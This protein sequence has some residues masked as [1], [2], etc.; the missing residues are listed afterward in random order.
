M[1]HTCAWYSWR[2]GEGFGS[3]E[4]KKKKDVCETSCWCWKL[5]IG[6]VDGQPVLL[7]IE[8]SLQCATFDFTSSIPVF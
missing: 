7:N 1:D 5:N 4:L 2:P 3:V 6:P 8:Q